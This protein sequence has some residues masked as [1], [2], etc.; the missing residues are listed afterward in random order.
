MNRENIFEFGKKTLLAGGLAI[1]AHG[2]VLAESIVEGQQYNQKLQGIGVDKFENT[3][4]YLIRHNTS[5][6]EDLSLEEL[7]RKALND[8][9]RENSD[10]KLYTLLPITIPDQ[11]PEESFYMVAT[12]CYSTSNQ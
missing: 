12:D 9:R 5:K 4:L 8:I 3:N 11:S 10:C 6:T 1:L 7:L 2:A